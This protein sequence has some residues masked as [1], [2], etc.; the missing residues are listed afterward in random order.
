MTSSFRAYSTILGLSGGMA[1][2]FFLFTSPHADTASIFGSIIGLV[3]VFFFSFALFPAVVH[4]SRRPDLAFIGMLVIYY[5]FGLLPLT[6]YRGYIDQQMWWGVLAVAVATFMVGRAAAGRL[7]VRAAHE[8]LNVSF[9]SSAAAFSL[10]IS[11]GCA[12]WIVAT[13]GLVTLNPEARF[14]ISA[15]LSYI[16]EISIPVVISKF[17][18][19]LCRLGRFSWRQLQLPLMTLLMLLTLGYRNQ[20][21]LLIIG[22]IIP[23]FVS[24]QDSS[25]LRRYRLTFASILPAA[26]FCF[27][28]LYLIRTNNSAGR[29]LSWESTVREFDVLLPE[30]TLPYVPLH[31]AAR[32]GM[33]VAES[34]LTKIDEIS[35]Y[36][37]RSWF[38]FSDF[39][40]ML[41]GYSVT[42]GRVLGMV[43]NGREDSSLTPSILGGLMIGYGTLGVAAF[44][45][46]SGFFM[47]RLVKLYERGRDPKSLALLTVSFIYMLELM[48]RGI[49]KPMY[50]IV[51]LVVSLL[52]RK[53]AS[54]KRT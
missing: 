17:C 32:E 31:L 14:A 36:V 51:I 45:L 41:P 26:M 27:G 49:F 2:L 46:L 4:I 6:T 21:I 37:N 8:P 1:A 35:D 13:H 40:T 44:F 52:F 7:P 39:L 18:F 11:A 48:N 38:F 47:G 20:P 29:T 53:S 24:V 3:P 10:L 16:V 43:V 22:L 42:S 54:I 25:H 9:R 34:S 50:I 5:S 23:V 28:I 12:I 33:G 30:F 15:K 19:D